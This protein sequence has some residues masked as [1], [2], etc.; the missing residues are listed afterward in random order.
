V[1]SYVWLG[2]SMF[3]LL[4]WAP[5]ADVKILVRTGGVVYELLR[6]VNVYWFWFSRAIARRAAPTILRAI[7]LFI[8]ARLFLGLEPP[9]SFASGCAWALTTIG[10]L[11]LAS[12]TSTLFGITL[13][14]TISGE[15]LHRLVSP[16]VMLLSGMLI[17]IPLMPS[18]AQGVLRV[19]PFRGLVDIPFR[20]YL[21]DIPASSLAPMFLH[22]LVWFALLACFGN[23]LL[24]RGMRRLVVQGG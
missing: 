9:A 18:W 13:M 11:L 24:N 17:P 12:A 2:Q 3:V 6:P 8:I 7:P 10:A 14:W 23:A 5:D 4:P 19:L 16:L 21:G 1:I 22:Q 20:L 15:G